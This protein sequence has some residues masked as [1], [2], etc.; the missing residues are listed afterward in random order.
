MP[1]DHLDA[2]G[3]PHARH[4]DR[5]DRAQRAARRRPGPA[6]QRRS[7]SRSRPSARTASWST[8]RR[9]ARPTST[10]SRPGTETLLNG[11]AVGDE[12]VVEVLTPYIGATPQV[13][14]TDLRPGTEQAHR[15]VHRLPHVDAR[16]VV[17]RV[18]R[19]LPVGR[20]A[21][22]GHVAGGRD[23]ADQHPRRRR[24]ST[25][26]RSRGSASPASRRRTGATATT[27]WWRRSGPAAAAQPCSRGNGM[28]MDQQSGLAWFDLE[29]A[30][31]FDINNLATS[32]QG[33]GVE[34]DLRAR[35][36]PL[37]GG[38]VVEPRRH[39]RC[40]SR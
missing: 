35:D 21:G 34:L 38:A 15:E 9:R 3:R 24:A 8:G 32:L 29:S 13:A 18:Q 31:T 4:A 26:S 40:C 16:R 20:G 1:K 36:R 6:R 37:R 19:L 2:A 25:R 30:A 23:A 22:V 10:A 5:G 28:D 27:S 12:G 7:T 14:M 17:H 33:H 39:A 11:F